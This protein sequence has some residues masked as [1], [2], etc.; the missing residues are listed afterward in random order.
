MS[1]WFGLKGRVPD[2]HSSYFGRQWCHFISSVIPCFI[3]SEVYV[4]YIMIYLSERKETSPFSWT[5]SVSVPEW[6]EVGEEIW[7][8]KGFWCTLWNTFRRVHKVYTRRYLIFG[9]RDDWTEGR[10]PVCENPRII[11][12]QF[13]YF[14]TYFGSHE[15]SFLISSR[16]SR[17]KRGPVT[18][19]KTSVSDTPLS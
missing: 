4:W 11:Y 7:G 19:P 18:R 2:H 15:I 6:S 17:T 8:R 16:G 5:S 3:R 12:T 1:E 9:S 14:V 13:I 10:V